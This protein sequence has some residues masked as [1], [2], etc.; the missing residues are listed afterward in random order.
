MKNPDNMI[1]R[2][3]LL[4][5]RFKTEVI[6][7]TDQKAIEKNITCALCID[8]NNATIHISRKAIVK[9]PLK[10]VADSLSKALEEL[11]KEVKI[12]SM[13]KINII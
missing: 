6:I 3:V 1:G 4:N 10:F 7:K 13:S 11:N 12:V 8:A 9:K 2:S 5:N